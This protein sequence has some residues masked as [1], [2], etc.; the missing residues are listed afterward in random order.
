LDR[1]F[2]DSSA[3]AKRYH[4]ETGTS[5]VMAIFA[6]PARE[7]RISRLTYVEVQSVFAMKVR[8]GFINR[9]EAGQQRAR[10]LLDIAAG[11]VEVCGVM[12]EHFAMAERLIGTHSFSARLRT[13]DAIQLAVALDLRK[14]NLPNTLS[15]PTE[16]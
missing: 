6:K 12:P 9:D 1:Y 8:G 11:E 4:R 2:F 3:F 5:A 10:L 13:L 7:I 15:L 16:L 14:R